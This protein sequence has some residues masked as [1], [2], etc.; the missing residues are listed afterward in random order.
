[1]KSLFRKALTNFSA[2]FSRF[3]FKAL[4]SLSWRA[5][6]F[7]LEVSSL[8]CFSTALTN[9]ESFFNSPFLAAASTFSIA[10][11]LSAALTI[12]V[13]IPSFNTKS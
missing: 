1:M 4:S 7:A 8:I 3:A 12:G 10:D 5:S 6:D 9:S 11:L 2:N 13:S